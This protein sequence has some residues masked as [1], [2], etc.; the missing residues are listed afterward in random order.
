MV[1][2]DVWNVAVGM[3]RGRPVSVSTEAS[4]SAD[5]CRLHWE[6]C[7]KQVLGAVPWTFATRWQALFQHLSDVPPE[8]LHSLALPADTVRVWDARS[9][10]PNFLSENSDRAV[11]FDVTQGVSGSR[12]ILTNDLSAEFQITRFVDVGVWPASAVRAVATLLA[13]H[14][15]IPLAGVEQGRFLRKEYEQTYLYELD[16]AMSEDVGPR[17]LVAGENKYISGRR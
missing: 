15:A 7:A 10:T 14:I 6:L 9:K 17:R 16:R 2:V 4:Q 8:G 1:T 12:V 13:S 3:V 5:A 11:Q